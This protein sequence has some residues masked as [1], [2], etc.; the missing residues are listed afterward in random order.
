MIRFVSSRPLL[1]A[2]A[3]SVAAC[4]LACAI[5]SFAGIPRDA[6]R[7]PNPVDLRAFRC[8]ALVVARG[9]D[10]YLSEPLHACERQAER[11][12]SI[13]SY[14]RLVVV[15]VPLP[16]YA[17]VLYRPLAWIS[18]QTASAYATVA[19]IAAALFLIAALRR[20]APLPLP[21]L[22]AIAIAGVWYPSVALG[23]PTV[24]VIAALVSVALL[25]RVRAFAAALPAC[26][27]AALA[28]HFFAP[29]LATLATVK[30]GRPLVVALLATLV[31]L[32]LAAGTGLTGEYL[33]RELP[34]HAISELAWF[35][36]Q[37]T[38]GAALVALGVRPGAALAT[39][40]VLWLGAV[41]GSIV[42]A[43]RL[44]ATTG[45]AA[46]LV[47]VP[48]ALALPWSP[49]LH[50]TWL[51]VA[52]PGALLLA[53]D[54]PRAARAVAAIV[55]IAIPWNEI[56]ALFP[57]LDVP[58]SLHYRADLRPNAVASD[59][60]RGFV[61][62]FARADRVPAWTLA[63]MKLPTWLGFG[64]LTLAAIE[65]A[66]PKPYAFASPSGRAGMPTT[67]ESA[68]TSR[69]TTAPA[70]TIAR[71]PTLLH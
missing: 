15:P 45:D 13:V 59:V 6:V 65:A 34:A 18:S 37:E 2:F 3:A 49:F 68:A 58:T 62:A 60:W 39:N 28:P 22:A 9:R 47:L 30:R 25:A 29:A 23:Q 55:L 64:A 10:P 51:G 43:R 12:G 19:T 38:L 46:Y 57:T 26:L 53:R 71:E 54:R 56:Y 33:L 11:E 67:S 21:L 41:I 63:L 50:A 42:I 16:P 32:S 24:F 4:A 7:V 66:F 1:G 44:A 40:D 52:L 61:S 27:V 69:T 8:G 70:P 20:L 14:G 35:R 17:F 36:G 5:A 48:I 31:V